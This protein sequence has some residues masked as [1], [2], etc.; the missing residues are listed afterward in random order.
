[1]PY[2]KITDREKFEDSINK[3]V[4]CITNPGDLNYIIY[5]ILVRTVKKIGLSYRL[6]SA[7]IA[8]LECCKM[9][10]YMKIL[11][12]YENRKCKDNGDVK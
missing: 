2:I 5:T 3:I 10:F 9:E 12:P 8:E 6:G 4:E 11:T 1:M 7:L